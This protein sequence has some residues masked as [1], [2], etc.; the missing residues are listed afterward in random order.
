MT[1]IT[2]IF[3][4]SAPEDIAR[5]PTLPTAHRKALHAIRNCRTGHY[6]HSL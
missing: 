4:A 5:P 6:G 1:T 3:T 2:D